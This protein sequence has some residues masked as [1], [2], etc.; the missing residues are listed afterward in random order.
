MAS[1]SLAWHH[2]AMDLALV[3]LVASARPHASIAAPA[4]QLSRR[5]A[6]IL[7]S[8]MDKLG[9]L[10][11]DFDDAVR[12]LHGSVVERIPAG[13]IFLIGT[14]QDGPIFGSIISGVGI[15]PSPNGVAL[16]RVTPDGRTLSLG[17]LQ[18]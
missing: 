1:P 7:A 9:S 4:L 6:L 11:F 15:T 18:P 17:G 3:P 5:D 12:A 2:H 10:P 13:R 8:T 16:V 14:T